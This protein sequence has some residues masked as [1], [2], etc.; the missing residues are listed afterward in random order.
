MSCREDQLLGL[1]SAHMLTQQLP[2]HSV[3]NHNAAVRGR[4]SEHMVATLASDLFAQNRKCYAPP[5]DPLRHV[6]MYQSAGVWFPRPL[7]LKTRAEK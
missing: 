2:E 1:G 4:L 3:Q 7:S 6:K 5:L